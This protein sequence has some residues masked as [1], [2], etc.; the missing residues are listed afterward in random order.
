MGCYQPALLAH[1]LQDAYILH[2]ALNVVEVL[3][4]KLHQKVC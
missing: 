4:V 1:C 2:V 3:A